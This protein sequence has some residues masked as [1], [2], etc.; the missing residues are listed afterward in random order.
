MFIRKQLS[1]ISSS[2]HCI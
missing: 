2:W 1:T